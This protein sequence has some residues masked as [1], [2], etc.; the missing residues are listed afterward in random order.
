MCNSQHDL[1]Y[2]NII[3]AVMKRKSGV[4][5]FLNSVRCMNLS[6]GSVG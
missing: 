3:H 4:Y 1:K 2:E 6:I 5:A